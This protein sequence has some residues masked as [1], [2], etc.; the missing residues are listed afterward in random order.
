VNKDSDY[1]IEGI[2]L[3]L[4]YAVALPSEQLVS[5]RKGKSLSFI[6]GGG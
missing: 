1:G 5:G 4:F 6:D 2:A 3:K